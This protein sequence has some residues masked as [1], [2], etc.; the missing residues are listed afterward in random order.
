M[1]SYPDDYGYW[2]EYVNYFAAAFERGRKAQTAGG[3]MSSGLTD[4]GKTEKCSVLICSPHPDDETITGTL[5]L[6]LSQEARLSVCNLAVTLGSNPA[7]KAERKREVLAACEVLHFALLLA[8]EP[9][10]FER[11]TSCTRGQDPASWQ[12]MVE[13]M[14]DHL[15]TREPDVVVF[16]HDRDNH[17]T[18]IGTHFLMLSALQK[19]S[20]QSAKEAIIVETECWHP[21]EDP[22]LLVGIKPQDIALLI[23][24][25]T[26]HKGEIARNPYHLR[27]PA[28]LMDNVRRGAELVGG[29]QQKAPDILFGELYRVSVLKNGGL[30]KPATRLVIGAEEPL[31]LA[32]L[33]ASFPVA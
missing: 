24:A 9:L 1:D 19:Y 27:F 8:R 14:A 30:Q 5:P 13:I 21:M 6:R 12:Q 7:R 29:H 26:R 15:L 2:L 10:A 33:K 16:P 32:L 20:Q 4:A 25:L 3:E 18:H 31:D 23:A 17:S 28:R 22:N 11:V